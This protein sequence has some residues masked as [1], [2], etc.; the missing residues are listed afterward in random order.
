MEWIADLWLPI[1]C[2]TAAVFV[3]AAL[4]WMVMPHH[5]K[6]YKALPEEEAV[7]KALQ[8]APPKPG[9]YYLPS[10]AITD[11]WKTEEGRKKFEEGPVA[12]LLV[13]P[14]GMPKM[15][16]KMLASFLYH[17]VVSIFVAYLG[18]LTVPAG[19]TF[20]QVF[21]VVGVGA[22]LAYSAAHFPFAIWFGRSM[23]AAFK[24]MGDGIAYGLI[25]AAIFGF[26][27]P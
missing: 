19:A 9:M 8:A 12:V 4:V 17:L 26:L 11:E 10:A 6:D 2:S 3:A 21:R 25:T 22:V 5:K 24:E 7:R 23:S 14:T 20:T 13:S 16:S 1:L 27:W 15:G 18:Q